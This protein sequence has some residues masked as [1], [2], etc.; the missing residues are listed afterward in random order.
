MANSSPSNGYFALNVRLGTQ[1]RPEDIYQGARLALAELLLSELEER[2]LD[3]VLERDVQPVDPRHRPVGDVVVAVPVPA[4]LRQ[5]VTPAH[6]DRVAVDD[7]PHTLTLDHEPEGVLGVP[8]LGGG[9]ARAEVLDRRP[10]RRRRV[11]AAAES[12]VGQRDRPALTTTPDGDQVPGLR[13][14]RLQ[15]RPPP[16]MRQ[17]S[18]RRLHRH[19]IADLLPQ[20]D[21]MLR[22]EGVVESAQFR[23]VLRLVVR[24]RRRGWRGNRVGH[25]GVLP[26]LRLRYR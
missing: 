11:G 10:Q 6:R 26:S 13:G 2:R 22:V 3:R 7:R 16:Q 23:R 1:F 12:R 21:E 4:C 20:R 24:G 9:L 18:R 5:E 15:R 14:Q 8:V 17:R 25:G 19:Q